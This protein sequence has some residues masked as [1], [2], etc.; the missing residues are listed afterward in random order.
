MQNYT[1]IRGKI[2]ASVLEIEKDSRNSRPETFRD[3]DFRL[4]D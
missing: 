3:F 4:Q 2:K 1:K